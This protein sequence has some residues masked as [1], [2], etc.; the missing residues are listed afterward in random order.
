MSKLVFIFSATLLFYSAKVSGQCFDSSACNFGNDQLQSCI[1]PGDPCDDGNV[2]TSGEIYN[3]SC[4]CFDPE[5][6]FLGCTD[7]NACNFSPLAEVNDDSCFY[8][9]ESCEDGNAFS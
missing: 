7:E 1:Y 5:E 9:G 8:F 2:L 3:S 6:F 4:N